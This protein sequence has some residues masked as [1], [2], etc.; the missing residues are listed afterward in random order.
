MPLIWKKYEGKKIVL[1]LVDIDPNSSRLSAVLLNKYGIPDNCEI[2]YIV[3][4]FLL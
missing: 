2:N 3:D 1:D 4:D